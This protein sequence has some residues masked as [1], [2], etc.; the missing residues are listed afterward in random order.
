MGFIRQ[1][2]E[3]LAIRLMTWQYQRMNHP[4]PNT[5]ELERHAKRVVDEAHRIAKESGNN[6]V[7]IMKE[8]VADLRK[9]R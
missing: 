4:V 1:Q 2:E 9:G 7:G 5:A 3:K 6:V 8:L